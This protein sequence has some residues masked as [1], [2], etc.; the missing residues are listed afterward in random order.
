MSSLFQP[1]IGHSLI[2]IIIIIRIAVP[3]CIQFTILQFSKANCFCVLAF[4]RLAGIYGVGICVFLSLPR[5]PNADKIIGHTSRTTERQT[6]MNKKLFISS[7]SYS[8][9][10]QLNWRGVGGRRHSLAAPPNECAGRTQ[11][12]CIHQNQMLH[13]Y[14]V[15][16][17]II[18]ITYCYWV[19]QG[20]T[21]LRNIAAKWRHTTRMHGTHT[22]NQ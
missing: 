18:I 4:C 3:F 8:F 22:A 9:T 1:T 14:Y 21:H 10:F 13:G 11:S 19:F 17:P 2:I 20:I 15:P 16:L 5:L 7:L 12:K 6:D